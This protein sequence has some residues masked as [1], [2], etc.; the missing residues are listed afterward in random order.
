M[1]SN[2]WLIAGVVAVVVVVLI[3]WQPWKKKD[4]KKTHVP[5]IERVVTV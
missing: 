2:Q 5:A 4:V 1:T 3:A